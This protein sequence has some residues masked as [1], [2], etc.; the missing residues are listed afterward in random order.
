MALAKYK[1]AAGHIPESA[2]LWN[3]LGMCFFGKKRFVSAVSCL[4]RANSFAPFDWK[5]LLN[6]G[7]VH[8]ATQQY[9]S[10]FHYLSSAINLDPMSGA[11]FLPLAGQWKYYLILNFCKV[12]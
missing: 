3:N 6:L 1:A 4:K 8:M 12:N 11:V 9:A 5:I 10:A 2:S 7:L